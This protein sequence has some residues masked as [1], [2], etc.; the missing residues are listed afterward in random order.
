MAEGLETSRRS[1]LK[2]GGAVGAGMVMG[3]PAAWAAKHVSKRGPAPVRPLTNIDEALA[4]PR[5]PHALPGPFPGRVAE[6]RD[7]AA[8]APDGTPDAAAVRAMFERGL[9]ALTGETPGAAWRRF[10]TPDDVVGI[11]VNPVGAGL[12]STRLELVDA[13]V[14]WL[15]AGGLP[16][17]NIVIWDRFDDMLRDAGFTPERFPGIDCAALQ[18]MDDA[19]Y[20]DPGGDQSGWLCPDGTHVSA[21]SF[22]PDAYYWV[23]VT[24]P[25]RDPAD[26]EKDAAACQYLN[27]HVFNGEHSYFGKLLTRRLTKIINL[28]VV[29]NTGNGISVAT[30]N[31]GYGA[32]CNTGRLHQ[33]ISFEVNTEVLAFPCLREKLVLNVADGLVAQYEGGPMPNA[34]FTWPLAAL[35]VATDPFALDRVC[36]DLLVAKRKEM[37]IAVNEHPIFTEYLRYGER[38]GLGVADPS[39]IDHQRV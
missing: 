33:P 36:H 21:G 38:L 28:P 30:K 7:A 37:G 11:K 23:E 8:L 6:V 35:F 25:Q 34:A 3:N 1:F 18:T 16:R 14:A 17:G 9:A 10:F 4:A 5:G 19:A 32:I 29:K 2:L 15:E 13:V 24:G 27:Q 39:R 22:D 12:I 26:P 20:M 31:L